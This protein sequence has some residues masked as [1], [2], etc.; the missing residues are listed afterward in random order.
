MG[1]LS[2]GKNGFDVKT[3]HIRSRDKLVLYGYM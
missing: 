2:H 3:F 1:N